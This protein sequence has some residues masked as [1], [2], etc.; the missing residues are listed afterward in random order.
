LPSP[1]VLHTIDNGGTIMGVQ[2]TSF[3]KLQRDRAKQAKQIAKR[4]RRAEK[5][6]GEGP[7]EEVEELPPLEGE[8]G[9]P[10]T[11][12]EMMSRIELIHKQ[13]DDG[14]LDL[15]EFDEQRQELLSRLPID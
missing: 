10:L 5:A 14:Q 4:E 3:G 8:N 7:E 2:R 1:P 15:D 13:Y 9:E 12:A 6:R 11:A